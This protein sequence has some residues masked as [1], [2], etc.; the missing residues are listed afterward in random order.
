MVIT[1]AG[2]KGISAGESTHLVI[3]NI[4]ISDAAIALAGKDLSEIYMNGVNI[5]RSQVGFIAYQKKP[6]YGAAR[7]EI[8]QVNL[9]S[10]DIPYLVEKKSKLIMDGILLK[11]L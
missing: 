2:D 1:G 3:D 4:N 7:I 8:T 6:E 11:M 10:V 5:R 9:E